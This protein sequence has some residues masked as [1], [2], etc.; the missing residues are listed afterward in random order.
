M[1]T[2]WQIKVDWDR[3]GD[4][5]DPADDI[6]AYVSF[7]DWELGMRRPYGD[8]ARDSVLEMTL[9]NSDRRFSPENASSPLVGKLGL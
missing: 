1:T 2:T 9:D 5:S 4:F 7:I 6:T 8:T 3:K